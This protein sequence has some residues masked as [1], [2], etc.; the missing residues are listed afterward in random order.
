MSYY[1]P[2]K[3][4]MFLCGFALTMDKIAYTV[5]VNNSD[6]TSIVSLVNLTARYFALNLCT[7]VS[8]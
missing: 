1:I 7:G 2:H 6:D 4:T 5:C 3:N 8:S